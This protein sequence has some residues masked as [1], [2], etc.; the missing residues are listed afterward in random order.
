MGHVVNASHFGAFTIFWSSDV[1]CLI[2][3]Y[4]LKLLTAA[5]KIQ[6]GLKVSQPNTLNAVIV[7]KLQ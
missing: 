6:G 3:K 4:G 1:N 5:Y 7:H 2:L